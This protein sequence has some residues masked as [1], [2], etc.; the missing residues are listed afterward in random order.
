[1]IGYGHGIIPLPV[2]RVK[3]QLEI[4]LETG[5]SESPSPGLPVTRDSGRQALLKF[6]ENLVPVTGSG[7]YRDCYS[8][9]VQGR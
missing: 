8:E 3:F 4:Q 6:Y 2:A 7:R 1:M 9:I 5:G